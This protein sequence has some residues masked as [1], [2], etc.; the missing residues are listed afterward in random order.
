M[1]A[2]Q[3]PEGAIVRGG[4]GIAPEMALSVVTGALATAVFWVVSLLRLLPSA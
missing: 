1:A 2:A 3:Y 4:V